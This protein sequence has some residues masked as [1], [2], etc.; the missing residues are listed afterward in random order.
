[1]IFYITRS[2]PRIT[3]YN[4]GGSLMREAAV[5]ILKRKGFKIK[6]IAPNY[7]YSNVIDN[8]NYLITP[9]N[10]NKISL[11]LQ[12][13]GIYSD[14]L[15]KWVDLTFNYLKDK[16]TKDDILFCTSGDDF[17]TI[18]LGYKLKI[19]I[20][21]KFIINHRDPLYKS[22]IYNQKLS[23]KKYNIPHV[24]REKL[25][26]KLLK[27]ADL[28]IT[29]SSKYKTALEFK[30]PEFKNIINNNFGFIKD[31][32][33]TSQKT[34][35]KEFEII[36]GGNMGSSQ[37]P[38]ILALAVKDLPNVKATFIGDYK[39]NK[40]LCALK[41]HINLLDTMSHDKYLEYLNKNADAGF[42]SLTN[43][44][45]E[46][47]VPSKLYEY[48]NLELPILGYINGQAKEIIIDN[49]FGYVG[50]NVEELKNNIIK[51]SNHENYNI[52][53]SNIK[54]N[55]LNWSMDKKLDEIVKYL[56]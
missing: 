44:F 28:I 56:S 34:K 11:I 17:G 22:K 47:C 30:Y 46:Y 6:V 41:D 15:D 19:E 52:I 37:S 24:S 45:S 48:I 54:K 23:T 53:S 4:K 42:L 27:S 18:I 36:Y 3:P 13:I 40:K 26:K 38:E 10:E 35:K 1:M 21:C 8:E 32:K 31:F 50:V 14:Y 16:I 29:S 25:E 55:K 20:G 9:F 49:E 2:F 5:L 39:T 33:Q 7:Y 43:D 51:L 12:H